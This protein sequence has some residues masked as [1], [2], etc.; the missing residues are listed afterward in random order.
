DGRSLKPLL[1]STPPVA[2]RQSFFLEEFNG[3]ITE[4]ADGDFVAAVK[5]GENDPASAV[6]IREPADA[7]DLLRYAAANVRDSEKTTAAAPPIPSYYGFKT[8]GYK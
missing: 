6:G 4:P 7:D 2:W 3:G 1:S 5:A 8:A